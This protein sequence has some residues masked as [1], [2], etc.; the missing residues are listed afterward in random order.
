MR[1]RTASETIRFIGGLEEKAASFYEELAKR[2]PDRQEP[3]LSLANENRKYVQ[4][5]RRTYQSVI[6]D[7]IEGCF[8]F[9]L[10]TENFVLDTEL[11]E[12][13]SLSEAAG[14]AITMEECI[15]RCYRAGAEQSGPLL[16]DLPRSFKIIVK[17]RQGRLDQLSSFR[18]EGCG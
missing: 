15:L 4:Q 17:K 7:A 18:W 1:L 6:S 9:D 16:A 11:G 5:V 10:D 3:F 14:K 13:A 12:G 8:A 2:F